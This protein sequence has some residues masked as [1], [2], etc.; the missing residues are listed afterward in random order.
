ML[1]SAFIL[2]LQYVRT[3][4][5]WTSKGDHDQKCRLK[6]RGNFGRQQSRANRMLGDQNSPKCDAAF[7]YRHPSHTPPPPPHS[8]LTHA[9][10]NHSS[11]T[12]TP[13]SVQQHGVVVEAIV[14]VINAMCET[15]VMAVQATVAA[16]HISNGVIVVL[17]L[18]GESV[19][20]AVNIV[21]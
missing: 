10:T 6:S 19:L 21:F 11:P 18:A 8:H 12:P 3:S 4:C 9:H 20:E 14:T 1:A 7:T 13:A 17:F 5:V 16:S 2:A 15:V